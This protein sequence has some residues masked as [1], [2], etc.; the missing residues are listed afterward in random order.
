MT[1][2]ASCA[3]DPS[4]DVLLV[5]MTGYAIRGPRGPRGVSKLPKP[6]RGRRCLLMR[7]VSSIALCRRA[8][9]NHIDMKPAR[10]SIA[11]L[12]AVLTTLA[13]ASAAPGGEPSE[14]S[15][16]T[17]PGESPQSALKAYNAAM[18]AG[19]VDGIVALQH[20][21]NETEARVARVIAKA[22]VEVAKLLE[23]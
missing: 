23:A 1:S 11:T 15:P 5:A 12:L 16:T 2:R 17:A 20:A 19:D 13:L 9:S 7:T 22:E 10:A 6:A 4:R 8:D 18:R 3:A 21:A 14:N